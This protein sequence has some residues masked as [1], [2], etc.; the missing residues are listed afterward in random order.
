MSKTRVHSLTLTISPHVVQYFG[1]LSE[2][3]K[4]LE[5]EEQLVW[6]NPEF[7]TLLSNTSEVRTH[8]NE[9]SLFVMKHIQHAH[10]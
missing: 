4:D 3:E 1:L 10:Y 6:S 7:R 9:L 2:D 5:A 8:S